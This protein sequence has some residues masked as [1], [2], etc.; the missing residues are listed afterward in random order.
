MRETNERHTSGAK[1]F[2][3]VQSLFTWNSLLLYIN[4]N[5][6][7][8]LNTRGS[9]MRGCNLTQVQQS[10]FSRATQ[11]SL[12]ELL[13]NLDLLYPRVVL[14]R[15]E[16]LQWLFI[17]LRCRIHILWNNHLQMFWKVKHIKFI[18]LLERTENHDSKVSTG[19]SWI[20]LNVSLND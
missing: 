11:A 3:L 10:P 19:V 7:F 1:F 5:D 12:F 20:E 17:V 14:G 16:H 15:F 6:S 2:R 13:F 8:V 4:Q 18:L 9:G